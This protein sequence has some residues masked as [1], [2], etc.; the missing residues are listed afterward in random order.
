M[1]RLLECNYEITPLSVRERMSSNIQEIKKALQLRFPGK[2]FVLGTC[3][4]ITILGSNVSEQEIF[5]ELKHLAS[6]IKRDHIVLLK[7]QEAI[8]HFFAT[9]SGLHSKTIGEHEILG[10]VRN[11]YM[12]QK[13]LEAELHELLKRAIYTGKRA[14]TETFIGKHATSLA[15]IT[16]HK[17]MNHFPVTANAKVLLL[18]TGNMAKLVLNRLKYL[19]LGSLDIA[20]TNLD[21][22]V[23]LANLPNHEGVSTKD[24]LNK[25]DQYDIIIGATSAQEPLLKKV[26][27]R[28]QLLI[29]LGMP[30]NFDGSL[31]KKGNITLLDLDDLEKSVVHH[32]NKRVQEIADVYHIINEE[33]VTMSRWLAFRKFVPQIT[34]LKAE[35]HWLERCIQDQ[36]EAS[37]Q[38]SAIH[39]AQM[40]YKARGVIQEHYALILT[41]YK[42]EID[43]EAL[44]EK[45]VAEILEELDQKLSILVVASPSIRKKA[46]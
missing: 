8:K 14:R 2:V 45:Y 19:P 7:D 6:D 26:S 27:P 12:D 40:R 15:S 32:K 13:E 17:I 9:A 38:M 30:R 3:Q 41:I 43:D 37:D 5:E 42:S 35:Q 44:I 46:A 11:A 18:G 22:A 29:D 33:L 34:R 21:R 23:S 31:G 20:S 4:R 39:K 1:I 36:V 28:R 24:A 25:V 16:I 10:Q